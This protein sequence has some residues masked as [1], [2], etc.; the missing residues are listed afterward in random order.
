VELLSVDDP[1]FVVDL[2]PPALAACRRDFLEAGDGQG[3]P[4]A[5]RELP[6]PPERPVRAIALVVALDQ[7]PTLVPIP[8]TRDMVALDATARLLRSALAT[9]RRVAELALLHGDDVLRELYLGRRLPPFIFDGF[10]APLRDRLPDGLW[11]LVP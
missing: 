3:P 4:L 9:G 11:D 6:D 8:G 5:E 10:P 2:T 1:V 7:D